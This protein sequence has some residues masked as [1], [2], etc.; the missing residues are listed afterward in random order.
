MTIV[1]KPA[2]IPF[3]CTSNK[4][5]DR[6]RYCSLVGSYTTPRLF[7]QQD[8]NG[9]S[10]AAITIFMSEV[11]KEFGKEKVE[12]DRNI[13]CY[14]QVSLL[15]FAAIKSPCPN[16]WTDAP[17]QQPHRSLYSRCP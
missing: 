14:R 16:P 3:W 7:L 10:A 5:V 11:K 9:F 2:D 13:L 4:T 15:S 1:C 12:P 8:S 6:Y 17:V